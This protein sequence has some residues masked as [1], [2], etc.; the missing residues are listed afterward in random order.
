MRKDYQTWQ[1]G[2]K[3]SIGISIVLAYFA[4]MFSIMFVQNF[5]LSCFAGLGA[6]LFSYGIILKNHRESTYKIFFTNT[7]TASQGIKNIL[8]DKGIPYEQVR[9]YF[10]VDVLTITVK[11]RRETRR[12]PAGTIIKI[13]PNKLIYEPLISNLQDKFDD[14][15]ISDW[16]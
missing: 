4:F 14:E 9:N 16:N 1:D 13:R 3:D 2:F 6:M 15:L 10:F 7:E 5:W 11:K 12:A 8:E